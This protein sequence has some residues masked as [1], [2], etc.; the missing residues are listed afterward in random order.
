MYWKY[1]EPEWGKRRI[2]CSVACEAL[3][4]A[5]KESRPGRQRMLTGGRPARALLQRT[6]QCWLLSN[7][8]SGTQTQKKKKKQKQSVCALLRR[9]AA[10]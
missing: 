5:S 1:T 10:Y 2:R 6:E 4:K 9:T 8:E 3:R 7:P